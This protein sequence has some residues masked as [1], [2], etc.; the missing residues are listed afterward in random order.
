MKDPRKNIAH[1]YKFIYKVKHIL[2]VTFTSYRR[3]LWLKATDVTFGY[4]TT[5]VAFGSKATVVTDG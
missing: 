1:M 4:P 5:G 3:N 2:K